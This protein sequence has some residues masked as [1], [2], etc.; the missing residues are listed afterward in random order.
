MRIVRLFY[1]NERDDI[2]KHMTPP[3]SHAI[4]LRRN[5]SEVFWE[6]YLVIGTTPTGRTFNIRNPQ[7]H[8]IRYKQLLIFH[9][10]FSCTDLCISFQEQ[11]WCSQHYVKIK[12]SPLLRIFIDPFQKYLTRHFYLSS[13]VM[14]L[15]GTLKVLLMAFLILSMQSYQHL[16]FQLQSSLNRIPI[17]FIYRSTPFV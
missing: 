16:L 10:S 4:E 3:P 17:R 8:N 5:Y 12:L 11:N 7:L 13:T 6:L 2:N 9:V 15:V 1:E 14:V